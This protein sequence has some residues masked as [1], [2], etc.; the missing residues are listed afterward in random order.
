VQ[1]LRHEPTT[2]AVAAERGALSALEASCKTAVG[3]HAWLAGGSV[4]LVV[5]A[6]SSDGRQRFRHEGET[7]TSQLADPEGSARALGLSLGLAVKQAGGA[8]ILG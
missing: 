8:A 3:A 6:L 2:L 1:A 5:E 7:E 4:R